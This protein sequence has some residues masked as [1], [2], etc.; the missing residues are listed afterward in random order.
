MNYCRNGTLS[1]APWPVLRTPLLAYCVNITAT[2][3]RAPWSAAPRAARTVGKPR[4]LR[5]PPRVLLTMLLTRRHASRSYLSITKYSRHLSSNARQPVTCVRGRLSARQREPVPP[6]GRR[7]HN[8]K[9][10]YSKP[11]AKTWILVQD[12]GTVPRICTHNPSP[13]EHVLDQNLNS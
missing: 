11:T 8:L 5:R 13:N 1:P 12:L 3:G 4:P 7:R 6:R 2:R 9:L 10:V